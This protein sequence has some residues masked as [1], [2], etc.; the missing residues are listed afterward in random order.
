MMKLF[1]EFINEDDTD[2]SSYLRKPSPVLLKSLESIGKG[3]DSDR[4]IIEAIERLGF[5]KS[6]KR[7]TS[8]SD[9]SFDDP[10][11]EAARYNSYTN[12]T[13]RYETDEKRWIGQKNR[14]LTPITRFKLET[15]RLRL[16]LI[17]RAVLKKK[18]LYKN[19]KKSGGTVKEFLHSI[20]GS[21][22][23]KEFG[24]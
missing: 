3:F 14:Y 23:G 20:R 17:L 21:L 22:A 4:E 15:S 8:S 24:I 9:F 18:D 6:R 16:L 10:D 19:W 1:D 11:R 5:K 7:I 12:G 2:E 13:V